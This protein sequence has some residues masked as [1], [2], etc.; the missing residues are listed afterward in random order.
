[1]PPTSRFVGREREL[2]EIIT[3]LLS[4][5]RLVSVTGPGGIGKTRLVEETVRRYRRATGTP[6]YWVRLARLAVHADD[7]SVE[8]EIARAVLTS[9]FSGDSDRE[10]IFSALT[11]VDAVGRR[12]PVILV[13]DNCEHVLDAVRPLVGELLRAVAG[14]T[15]VATTRQPLHIEGE[16]VVRV[17][18]LAGKQARTL[19]RN[20]AVLTGQDIDSGD[21][22]AE[23]VGE[24][25]RRVHDNPLY[26]GLA[27]ARLRHQPLHG[28]LRE[29]S[30]AADDR[31]MRWSHGPRVGADRRH[32]GV[33]D[34]I[35]WSYELCEPD[36]QLLLERLSVFAAG[37]DSAETDSGS[38]VG[39]ELSAIRAVCADPEQAPGSWIDPDRVAVLL[40]GLV[41]R[42]LVIAH[43]TPTTLRYS[44]LQTIRLFAGQQLGQRDGAETARLADLHRRYYRD[45][46]MHARAIWYSPDEQ[47]LLD[48]ARGAWDNLL[49]AVEGS[50]AAPGDAEIGL[51]I[52]TGLIAL[53]AP[54][55]LGTMREMR[56]WA[57]R[58]ILADQRSHPG[59]SPARAAALAMTGWLTLC[60]GR[61]DDAERTLTEALRAFGADPAAGKV[62]ATELPAP[63]ALAD[64]ARRMLIDRDSSAVAVFG[65]ARTKFCSSGDFGGA[66][67]AEMFEAL[68]AGF[69]G[70]GTVAE[71][72]TH[73]HLNA[74]RLS[75]ASWAISWAELASAIASV[76][77]GD[78]RTALAV[79]RTALE[80]QLDHR[81][82]WGAL[83]AVHIIAWAIAAD[84]RKQ[85][86]SGLGG[87][88][89][90]G[91]ARETA[92]LSG[93][94]RTLRAHL[95]VD[96]EGL[97][98]FADQTRA[99]IETARGVLGD[100]AYQDAELD[101]AKMLPRR[102][103]VHYRA[104]GPP[105]PHDEE[106]VTDVRTEWGELTVA[107]RH[108]AVLAASGLTN[109]A[110]AA[111]RGSSSRT[112]AAQI[113]SVL[114]KLMI[115]TRR[116]IL[117]FVP[118]GLL[119]PSA[120]KAYVVD[121]LCA[122]RR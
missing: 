51:E 41:D 59:P 36:E 111:R 80:R 47:R 93:G 109:T 97:G 16:Q 18:P 9:D 74:A 58:A 1:M 114:Q 81:D 11:R 25:C 26:I 86:P 38:A 40:A 10:A 60:Q 15:V 23:I 92:L 28:V 55:F 70:P 98:P 82:Q 57:E 73:R 43:E 104:L 32:R 39:A 61:R 24:I 90:A 14:L 63:V 110:I 6:V 42:S 121:P 94:A 107:E 77:F 35:G 5:T 2:D 19:F 8:Q 29:L 120:T 115:G 52:V 30:G 22:T 68:A 89:I 78:P 50:V 46:I 103:E 44:M 13:L 91:A 31:R 48:W 3:L 118:P 12:L 83:W 53:R 69:F 100:T 85:L 99:A 72:I 62:P 76:R 96:L 105:M 122:R 56:R 34:V 101:G 33:I 119:D 117:Q 45:Q 87:E 112:V 95:G 21:A 113:S 49:V 7:V 88:A 20:R 102:S 108:V 54:F 106:P 64:G 17:H 4:R 71:Q 66:A 27:A 37:Y 116:E 84:I 67:I 79:A 75:G 65:V